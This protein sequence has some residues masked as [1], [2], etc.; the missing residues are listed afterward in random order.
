MAHFSIFRVVE[1]LEKK[2]FSVAGK[3]WKR[4]RLKALE[5]KFFSKTER[6]KAFCIISHYRQKWCWFVRS[7]AENN[8]LRWQFAYN[9]YY[10][11][12]CGIKA[13]DK[14]GQSVGGKC[15]FYLEGG[16]FNQNASEGVFTSDISQFPVS[17]FQVRSG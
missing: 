15:L 3:I 7:E 11:I 14:L 2:S 16:I 13:S 4:C 9:V 8:G 17:D 5:A 1:A 10:V 6:R 12:C